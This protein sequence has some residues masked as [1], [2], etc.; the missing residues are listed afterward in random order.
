LYKILA[1]VQVRS[2]LIFWAAK[3]QL[4]SY[5]NYR[6]ESGDFVKT[7]CKVCELRE[8]GESQEGKGKSFQGGSVVSGTEMG[9]EVVEILALNPYSYRIFTHGNGRY[10]V[11]VLL[12]KNEPCPV[13]R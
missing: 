13:V 4:H 8:S 11:K 3:R 12:F 10:P 5:G 2:P 6:Q 9:S 1:S 7:I